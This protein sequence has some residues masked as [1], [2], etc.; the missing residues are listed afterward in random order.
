MSGMITR[1]NWFL[2]IASWCALGFAVSQTFASWCNC[3]FAQ[4]NIVPDNTLGAES[5]VVTPNVDINGITSDRIDGGA[6]RGANLFHSF[7][8]FNIDEGRGA[9]F[10][11]PAGIENI[12]SRVTG[13]NA[14]NILGKLGVLGNANV[15]LINPSGIIFGRN[16][17]LD[18]K[19]SFVAST[20]SSLNFAE[21]INAPNGFIIA[22]GGENSDITAN[23]FSGSGGE[24]TINATDIFGI[25]P[26]NRQELERLRPKDLDPRLLTTSDITAIS[27]ISPNLSGTISINT[28]DVDANRGLVNLPTVPLE[29]EVSQICQPRTA[30]NQ[31]S[32]TITGRGGLPPNP[33]TEPL[34]GDAVQVDWVTLNPR[35]QNRSSP[36]VTTN[37]TP[38]IPA[39]IAEAQGWGRNAEGQVVLTA[40]VPTTPYSSWQTPTECYGS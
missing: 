10:T 39:P 33:R 20:A 2:K 17:S 16:A 19:G 4:S 3:A 28:R 7:Q 40:N 8:E 23:A 24:V 32:F 26:L 9:Y 14:S 30:Q 5:S 21:S 12:L 15:F 22:V 29:T 37:P 38:T 1:W 18:V 35:R 31:S 27:Q 36:K 34:S 6:I 25:A 13:G 11:N